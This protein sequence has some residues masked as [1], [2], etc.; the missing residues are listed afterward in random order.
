V[1]ALDG[2]AAVAWPEMRLLDRYL[3]RELLTPFAYCLGGILI[4]WISF[5]LYSELSEFQRSKLNG[6]DIVQYYLV[7]LPE[8]LVFPLLPIVLLLALLYALTNHARYHELTAMRA[9]GISLWRLSLPY[10]G[11]GLVLT[12]A[13]SAMNQLWVPQIGQAAEMILT[14]HIS[15]AEQSPQRKWEHNVVFN[16]P[17]E[18]R[19]WHIADYN[20]ATHQMVSPTVGWTLPDGTRREI[21][22]ESGERL[23]NVWVFTN[24]Q[25][26]VYPP[27]PGATPSGPFRTNVLA[28]PEFSETPEDIKI[29]IK[30]NKLSGFNQVQKA[31]LSNREILEYKKNHPEDSPKGAMLETELQD[32]YA[33]PWTC[34]VVV[35]VALP[36]AAASGRRNV[37][38][39]VASSLGICFAYFV[40]MKVALA[41]G[42]VGK[43]EPWLAGWAPNVLFALG[44]VGLTWRVR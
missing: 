14:R 3:L 26:L 13:S 15:Q 36:F 23:E 11:V 41:M 1:L 12:F 35:L 42:S 2:K 9:A 43:L 22:A 27:T 34:L 28:L 16:N 25:M 37:Y 44:G 29:E 19:E 4:F 6:L 24:A 39:G 32:H 8:M 10:V 7:Q 21:S 30:V 5:D 31:R 40:T 20:V 18:R 38:V 33:T 17:R